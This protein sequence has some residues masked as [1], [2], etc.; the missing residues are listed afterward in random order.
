MVTNNYRI[1]FEITSYGEVMIGSESEEKAIEYFNKHYDFFDLLRLN[2]IIK[3]DKP[4]A[5]EVML[6]EA[7][8]LQR[9]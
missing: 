9:N 5:I 1:K 6:E 7:S 4:K 2:A 3:S 8:V